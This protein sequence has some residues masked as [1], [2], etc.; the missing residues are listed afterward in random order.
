MA[1]EKTHVSAIGVQQ[2]AEQLV[3]GGHYDPDSVSAVAD[4]VTVRWKSLMMRAEE[5]HKLVI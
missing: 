4:G 3:G 2:R 5:K 1:I